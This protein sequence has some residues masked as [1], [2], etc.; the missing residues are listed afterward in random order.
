MKKIII[1]LVIVL[2]IVATVGYM[3]LNYKITYN[4]AKVEN[5]QY[6]S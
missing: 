5:Q 4:K 1:F 6:E 2:I 3:Y